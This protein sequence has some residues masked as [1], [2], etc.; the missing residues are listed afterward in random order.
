MNVP[1]P[2]S[3]VCLRM[4]WL[5]FL[6]IQQAALCLEKHNNVYYYICCLQLENYL[7]LSQPATVYVA[8]A[9]V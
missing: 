5:Y 4:Q 6:V 8:I 1:V 7:T 9:H 2:N 3:Q